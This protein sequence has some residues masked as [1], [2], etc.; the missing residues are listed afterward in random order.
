MRSFR[1]SYLFAKQFLYHISSLP[2]IRN[3]TANINILAQSDLRAGLASFMAITDDTFYRLDLKLSFC[4][5]S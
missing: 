5:T 2:A 4:Y 1:W 3:T